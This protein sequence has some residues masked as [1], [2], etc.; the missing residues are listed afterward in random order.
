LNVIFIKRGLSDVIQSIQR[1]QLVCYLAWSETR[2]RYR[3]SFLGPF[4]IVLSTTVSV[5]GLGYLW[6]LL[7]NDDPSKLVPSLTVGLV[8]WQFIASCITEAPS[9][10][11]R[12]SHFIKNMR[13]PFFIFPLNLLLRNT[14]NFAHNLIVI[15]IVLLF[16]PPEFSFLQIYII[17]GFILVIVNLAWLILLIGLINSRYRDF[18]Q[19]INTSMP[20]LFFLS[21]VIFRESQLNLNEYLVWFNPFSYL[22]ALIRNPMMGIQTP[23][24]VYEVSIAFF[25]IG[26]CFTI[27]QF[28]KIKGRIAFWM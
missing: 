11:L 12:N 23:I 16:Y 4:W 26:G 25:V 1:F 18:E 3:R 20:L 28:G 14:I 22:L 24:F 17:P 7:L 2:A 10:F 19:I 13:L 6:S 21:P 27:Y 9:I 15:I 5:A 8:I